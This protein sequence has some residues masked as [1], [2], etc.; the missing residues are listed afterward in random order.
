MRKSFSLFLLIFSI[1]IGKSQTIT[2]TGKV[3]LQGA[4]NTS[5]GTMNNTLNS[6]GILQTHAAF[7]PYNIP[8]FENYAGT[9]TVGAGF[10]A[11]HTDIVDWVLVELRESSLLSSLVSRRAAF[12]KTD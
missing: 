12:V 4:Y 1:L 7:Q 3:F 10:F 5:T 11:A 2:F 9:E 6:L 8:A